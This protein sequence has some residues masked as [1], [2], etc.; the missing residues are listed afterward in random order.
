MDWIE[1]KWTVMEDRGI[2]VT[3]LSTT[4][5]VARWVNGIGHV[6]YL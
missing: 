6:F 2:M 3:V 1:Y 4:G 5:K